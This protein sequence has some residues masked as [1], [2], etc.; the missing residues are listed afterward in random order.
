MIWADILRKNGQEF[1]DDLIK[2]ARFYRRSRAEYSETRELFRMN[3][4][5]DKFTMEDAF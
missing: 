5:R 4:S 1:V 2:D 3:E